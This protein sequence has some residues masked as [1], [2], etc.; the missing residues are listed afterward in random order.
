MKQIV[1]M[2]WTDKVAFEGD[3]DGHKVTVDASEESGGGDLGL[4]P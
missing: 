2:A 4:R 1:D 3:M